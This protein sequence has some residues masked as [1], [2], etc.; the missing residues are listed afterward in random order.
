MKTVRLFFL[1]H[2]PYCVKAKQAIAELCAENPDYQKIRI[3]SINEEVQPGI[4]EQ[5]D[6]YYVPT[7][8]YGDEKLYEAQPGQ[9]YE[10]I[11]ENFRMAFDRIQEDV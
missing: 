3:E 6:Y 4:A 2:C 9:S 11:K 5:Y 7:L 8:F 1:T 10:T